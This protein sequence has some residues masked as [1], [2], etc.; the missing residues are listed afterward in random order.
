[1]IEGLKY[2]S[3]HSFLRAGAAGNFPECGGVV[4]DGHEADAVRAPPASLAWEELRGELKM[5]STDDGLIGGGELGKLIRTR[6][7]GGSPLGEI[8]AWPASLKQTLGLLLPARVQIVLFWGPD[9]IAFYNDAYAP[10]IGNK[11]PTALGR[12]ARENWSELWDDLE[13]LLRGVRETGETFFAKDRRFVIERHG[14]LEHVYF[15][16]S[17]SAVPD[18]SGG[19]GGVLCIVNETTE[20]VLAARRLRESEERFRLVAESAPVMLWMGDETGKCIYLNRALRAFWDVSEDGLPEFDWT[21]SIHPDDREPLFASFAEGMRSQLP[22][23]VEARYRR[24]DGEYRMLH[25]NAEPRKDPNGAF[26]GMIG[27]NVDLTEIRQAEEA[28]RLLNATL[29]ER[30]A[31]E[32]AERSRAEAA[33]IQAQKAEAIGQLTGGIAHDFNNML[34]VVIG[35]LNLLERRLAKGETNVSKYIESALEGANRAASLTQRLLAFARRQPLAPAPLDVNRLVAGMSDLLMRALG[36]RVRLETVLLAGLWKTNVDHVQLESAILNLCVNGR[37][38]MPSGGRLTIETANVHVDPADAQ[39]FDAPAGQ[40]VQISVSDQG[41]GMTSDVTAKAFDPFF[42]TKDVGKGTGLG[43]SQ[44]FGFVRQSGGQVRLYSEVGHGTTVKIYLP[45]YDGEA[46]AP[47]PQRPSDGGRTGN[48]EEIILLVEDEERV[49]AFAAEALQQLGYTV[50]IAANGP[51]ALKLLSGGVRPHL[52]LTDVVM[53][54][55]TGRELANVAAGML[56]LLKVLYMTGYTRNAVVHNGVIDPFTHVVA[57]P[58]SID[59][60]ADKVREVLDR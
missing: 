15:D 27:V 33:L 16:V 50:L 11:H 4:N 22:F 24:A 30:I 29:E 8:G 13:P 19:I 47:E 5:R 53:P 14:Y 44:V 49:R 48:P 1:M 57:K 9:Y 38:A 7:W 25:T 28:L 46:A 43:L 31:R 45:R 6:N 23:S 32:V 20:Q 34:A 52:L 59:Q 35:S 36:E 55:M 60:L 54:D 18:G 2:K 56:P 51:Q 39:A 21:V 12:P 37:D 40:Y 42:T 58:F 41:T 10:T 3:E 17:Y 26:L